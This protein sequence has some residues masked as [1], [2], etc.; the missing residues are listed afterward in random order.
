MVL[1]AVAAYILLQIKLLWNDTGESYQGE[2]I[3]G[4]F[5]GYGKIFNNQK[6]TFTKKNVW[7]SKM[8][9]IQPPRRKHSA[10]FS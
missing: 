4:K 6:E 10:L 8:G 1:Q 7:V 5:C 2:F 3:D 9:L